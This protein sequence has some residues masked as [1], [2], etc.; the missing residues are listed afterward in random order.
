MEIDHI[1]VLMMEN[2]SFDHMLGYLR[3]KGGRQ[4]VDGL[5]GNEVNF[6]DRKVAYKP[7]RLAS[8]VFEPDPCHEWDCV[9]EQLRGG[10]GGFIENYAT[11][12]KKPW[13]PQR[14]MHYFGSSDLPVFDHLARD[15]CVCDRWFS[16]IPGPTQPNRA[17]AL[18]GESQG[19]KKNHR[20]PMG[21]YDVPTVFDVLPKKVSWRY[22]SHDIAFLRTFKKYETSILDPIGEVEEFFEAA[23]EGNLPNVCWIDPDFGIRPDFNSQNDDHPPADV[24][25][26]QDLV[27]RVY[28]A[29]IEGGR[30]L[31]K[32]TLLVV[33]YD[34]HGGFYDHVDPTLWT[35]AD[36]RKAFQKYGV[37]VPAFV[38][39]PWVGKGV[40][41][42]SQPGHLDPARVVFDHTCIIKTILLR[43]C[44][45]PDGSIPRLTARVE[46]AN[47]LGGL[48]TQ[49]APRTDCTPTL[50]VRM[51]AAAVSAPS[52]LA[53]ASRTAGD[54]KHPKSTAT[55]PETVEREYSELQRSLINLRDKA[56]RRGV[57]PDKL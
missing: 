7:K 44:R 28:N 11:I 20:F 18:A 38:V 12:E 10:N 4:D 41:F 26:G 43:F 24:R 52:R 49:E 21:I 14:I 56:L 53:V 2:R 29:L 8:T 6:Y 17:Y 37:R 3:L 31:W 23:S 46:A 33:T 16:S 27:G 35:P 50:P 57:P 45:R 47:D 40:A 1:V 42:G 36:D 25:R 54:R 5:T 48:L 51:R 32:K 19:R 15:F 22:Y 55:A 9:A 34:E 13:R 30:N 39:S